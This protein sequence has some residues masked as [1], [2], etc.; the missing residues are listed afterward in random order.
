MKWRRWLRGQ[1][2]GNYRLTIRQ[3]LRVFWC[4]LCSWPAA[5]IIGVMSL[6]LLIVIGLEEFGGD[7]GHGLMDS[8]GTWPI[9]G[10]L[11]LIPLIAGPVIFARAVQRRCNSVLR[12]MGFPVCVNCQYDLKGLEADPLADRCP[13]CGFLIAD[14][15]AVGG[16]KETGTPA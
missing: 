16:R 1:R 13:E 11:C 3:E 8:P 6:S 4:T 2:F 15:P 9:I 12:C 7:W 5:G 10:V 14:M